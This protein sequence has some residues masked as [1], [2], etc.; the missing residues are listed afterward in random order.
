MYFIDS[1]INDIPILDFEK[2]N[3][4]KY[5]VNTREL[6]KELKEYE[7][8]IPTEY[9]NAYD[10]FMNEIVKNENE[11][12][13]YNTYNYNSNIIHDLQYSIYGKDD[14]NEVYV[15]ISVH[16]FGDIRGNYTDYCILKF[17]NWYAW[18]EIVSDICRNISFNILEYKGKHYECYT[19][20]YT[21]Y[22][23]VW[24]R[25]TEQE[26]EI[27]VCSEDDLKEKIDYEE[28]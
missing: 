17:D 11:L 18:Y 25:E 22:I 1:I 6:L 27:C 2:T 24:C 19:D 9:N 14:N 3:D 7:I 12:K 13:S 16:R 23:N 10:Y 8:E 20:I 5:Y 28:S 4:S 26:Y 21:E 15:A